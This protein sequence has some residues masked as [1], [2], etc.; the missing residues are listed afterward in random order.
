M[1]DLRDALRTCLAALPARER[2]IVTLRYI[3]DLPQ[4]QI[5]AEVGLSQMQVSR[6]LARSVARLRES[7]LA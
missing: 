1:A 4:H 5:G 2:R 3:A 6:L 7:L